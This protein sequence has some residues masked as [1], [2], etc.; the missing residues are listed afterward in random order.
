MAI[1]GG[2][3]ISVTDVSDAL[4]TTD[5]LPPRGASNGTLWLDGKTLKKY[6]NG[7]WVIQEIDVTKLDPDLAEKIEGIMDNL[8]TIGDDS[9]LTFNDRSIL[10]R[11][12][13]EI[14]GVIPSK[15]TGNVYPSS[16]PAY[17]V[18]DSS[19]SGTFSNVR[20]RAV[21]VG[22]DVNDS[23]YKAVET[24]YTSLNSYLS[25][26]T[27][28]AWDITTANKD[29][30]VTLTDPDM[31]RQKFLD[32][33][34]AELK[35]ATE[36]ERVAKESAEDYADTITDG[37]SLKDKTEILSGNPII[38]DKADD[39]SVVHVEVD[40]K[41]VGGGSG[42][43]LFN[44]ER[45]VSETHPLSYENLDSHLVIKRVDGTGV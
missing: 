20:A 27:P 35:L 17:N 23:R 36:V 26:Y 24:A 32:Y 31:F 2:S 22:M 34:T 1:L 21:T 39:N 6:E 11:E 5:G 13:G 14:I 45:Y 30:I 40:G 3:G 19:G 38:T 43:N 28:K 8:G 29:K 10:A 42:K 44:T 25:Q 12:L 37:V 15:S 41:S 18:L 4:V 9:K 33:Y 16:L 7:N